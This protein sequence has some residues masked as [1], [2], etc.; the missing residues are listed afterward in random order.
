[1]YN[2]K[3][4]VYMTRTIWILYVILNSVIVISLDI[5]KKCTSCYWLEP[6]A[7]NVK[8]A[9]GLI[10]FHLRKAGGS[11]FL[12]VIHQWLKLHDCIRGPNRD[13]VHYT[14]VRGIEDGKFLLGPPHTI[15]CPYVSVNHQEFKCFDYNAM[16]MLPKRNERSSSSRFHIFTILRDPIER[17]GS[18]AFYGEECVGTRVLEDTIYDVCVSGSDPWIPKNEIK[19]M[20]HHCKRKP[21]HNLSKH[22]QCAMNGLKKGLEILRTNETIW[23]DW[24]RKNDFNAYGDG[25]KQ[26][27][28]VERLVGASMYLAKNDNITRSEALKCFQRQACRHLRA[29][30]LGTLLPISRCNTHNSSRHL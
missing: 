29:D 9:T 11:Q 5:R 27:Y 24:L 2:C 8:P 21:Q 20:I 10:F 4:F 26:N 19:S 28:Y 30:L 13:D 18:Q 1:M 16:A 22:C 23:M 6:R 12:D 17:I 3:L 25:Y 14:V 15:Y 7:T